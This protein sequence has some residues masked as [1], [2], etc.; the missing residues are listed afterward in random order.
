MPP[1]ERNDISLYS[2]IVKFNSVEAEGYCNSVFWG[3]MIKIRKL[4][5]NWRYFLQN[6]DTIPFKIFQRP[7]Y[8]SVCDSPFRLYIWKILKYMFIQII[9][10]CHFNEQHT[11]IVVA[12]RFFLCISIVLAKANLETRIANEKKLKPVFKSFMWIMMC[13]KCHQCLTLNYVRCLSSLIQVGT[14]E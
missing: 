10:M 9:Y 8:K 4:T 7:H 2:F 14:F 12:I 3:F 1:S 11:W 5:C 6:V 13:V